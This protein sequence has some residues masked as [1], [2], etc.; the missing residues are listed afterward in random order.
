[1]M[2]HDES[3]NNVDTY[4]QYLQNVTQ[5]PRHAIY[6]KTRNLNLARFLSYPCMLKIGYHSAQKSNAFAI[7]YLVRTPS[8]SATMS[9]IILLR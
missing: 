3:A 6:V 7:V 1:M 5:L 8:Q 2:N 9:V 4:L